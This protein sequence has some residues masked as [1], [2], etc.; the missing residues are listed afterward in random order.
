MPKFPVKQIIFDINK[1]YANPNMQDESTAIFEIYR[2]LVTRYSVIPKLS[3]KMMK[4]NFYLDVLEGFELV[5]SHLGQ[6]PTDYVK[7]FLSI[8]LREPEDTT[9]LSAMTRYYR[10]KTAYQC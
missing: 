7:S 1:K 2:D 3:F 5:Q 4:I 6:N 9:D 10:K 8:D